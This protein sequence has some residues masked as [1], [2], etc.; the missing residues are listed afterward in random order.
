VQANQRNVTTLDKMA[1]ANN[2]NTQ[3]QLTVN[4]KN[5]VGVIYRHVPRANNTKKCKSNTTLSSS[6]INNIYD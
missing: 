6:Y 4:I 2:N 5:G 3:T 1:Y